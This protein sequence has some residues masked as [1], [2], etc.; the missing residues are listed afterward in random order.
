MVDYMMA[1]VLSK[2]NKKKKSKSRESSRVGG[3][4]VTWMWVGSSRIVGT[5]TDTVVGL[6]IPC[7]W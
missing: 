5:D 7:L 2:K 1:N 6:S 3:M 4:E